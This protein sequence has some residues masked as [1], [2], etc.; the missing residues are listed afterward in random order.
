MPLKFYIRL[1]SIAPVYVNPQVIREINHESGWVECFDLM[2]LGIL[3]TETKARCTM[4]IM[5]YCALE[6]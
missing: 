3:A 6:A 2:H 1:L 5:I 4:T